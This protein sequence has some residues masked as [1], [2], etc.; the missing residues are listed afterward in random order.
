L[1]IRTDAT[2]ATLFPNGVAIIGVGTEPSLK[3]SIIDTE[4]NIVIADIPNMVDVG[5]FYCGIA[6]ATFN[7]QGKFTSDYI[8]TA[9]K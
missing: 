8:D 9:G 1:S 3:W 4:G 2:Y 6:S 7:E 5:Y